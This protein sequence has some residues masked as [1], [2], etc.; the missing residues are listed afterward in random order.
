MVTGPTGPGPPASLRAPAVQ[1]LWESI[2]SR[3]DRH[4]PDH[5]SQVVVGD[6]PD[7]ASLVLRSLLGR[8][9]A[10]IDLTELEAALVGLGVGPDLDRALT[11]LG[12]P[13]SP[14]ATERRAA[15]AR[16]VEIRQRIDEAV[17]GWPEPWAGRWATEVVASGAVSKLTPDQIEPLVDDVRRLLDLIDGRRRLSP[18]LVGDGRGR[19]SRVDVAARLFGSAHGLDSSTLRQ[20][21]CRRALALRSGGSEGGSVGES[22]FGS[23]SEPDGSALA[24]HLVEHEVWDAAGIHLDRV[25]SPILTWGLDLAGGSA[26]A[27]LARA[28][29]RAGFPFP[30]TTAALERCPV[31]GLTHR[32]PILVVENPRVVEA[33]ADAAAGLA[34]M[35]TNG[36]PR[37][38]VV[39]LVADLVQAGSEVHYHGDFDSAGLAICARMVE[40]GC[41]PYAMSD[42]DYEVACAQAAAERASLVFDGSPAGPTPWSPRLQEA[43]NHHH[44]RRVIHEEFVLNQLLAFDP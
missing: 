42:G 13:P 40:L 8:G 32:G 1:S 34:V 31:A 35:T 12:H 37:R 10:R 21:L 19:W 30:L 41:R 20:R 22:G 16:T 7:E 28:S 26:I 11:T 29:T 9:G 5:R 23:E 24:D 6:L 38:N 18:A 25:S 44:G 3:L 39:A 33:A 17:A 2:R 36:N 14:A 43:F 27:E 15:R 4:G